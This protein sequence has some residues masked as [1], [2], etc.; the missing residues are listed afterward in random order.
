MPDGAQ[1]DA[2]CRVVLEGLVKAHADMTVERVADLIDLENFREV[3]R[4]IMGV[5]GL[6]ERPTEPATG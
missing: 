4:A 2:M 6:E 1:L 3:V 5:S